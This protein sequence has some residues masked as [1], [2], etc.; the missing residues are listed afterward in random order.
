MT[1]ETLK[2]IAMRYGM[3][4]ARHPM[5]GQAT[6][7]CCD[8]DKAI[9]ELDDMAADTDYTNTPVIAEEVAGMWRYRIIIPPG[10]ADLYGWT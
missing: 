1:K 7:L 9:P 6:M 2:A 5:T 3:D 10:W 8:S 4:L